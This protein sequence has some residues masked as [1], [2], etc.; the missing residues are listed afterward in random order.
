MA[1]GVHSEG[2]IAP[3]DNLIPLKTGQQE[4]FTL[5][6][7]RP[8]STSRKH[9]KTPKSH[10]I[11]N[12]RTQSTAIART[13]RKKVVSLHRYSGARDANLND[14]SINSVQVNENENLP[15]NTHSIPPLVV[16]IYTQLGWWLAS[17]RDLWHEWVDGKQAAHRGAAGRSY[18]AIAVYLQ[19]RSWI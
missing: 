1:F 19:N 15:R 14:T 18:F 8:S 4:S 16:L 13:T 7:V 11:G 17:S 2:T 9:P 12:N 3:M 6:S 10:E 5:P